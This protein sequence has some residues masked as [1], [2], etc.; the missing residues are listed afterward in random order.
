SLRR[1]LLRAQGDDG[2]EREDPGARSPRSAAHCPR[3]LLGVD[4]LA[5]SDAHGGQEEGHGEREGGGDADTESEDATEVERTAAEARE[6]AAEGPGR[7]AGTRA[8]VEPGLRVEEPALVEARVWPVA[9]SI[10]ERV[11]G[12][13]S[14]GE[15]VPGQA[16]RGGPK[17]HCPA[18]LLSVAED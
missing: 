7:D 1:G 10:L 2:R 9:A 18:R 15:R 6:G 14:L 11:L 5:S 3:R 13:R 17:D 16:F 8:E 12:R 4:R